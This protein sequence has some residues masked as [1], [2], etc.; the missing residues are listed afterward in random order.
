MF[1]T[2]PSPLQMGGGGGGGGKY[3]RFLAPLN[4]DMR[5]RPPRLSDSP[6]PWTPADQLTLHWELVSIL[7]ALS[8][9]RPCSIKSSQPVSFCLLCSRNIWPPPQS[10]LELQPETWAGSELGWSRAR[11]TTPFM[12]VSEDHQRDMSR[13][14]ARVRTTGTG[15][16]D[17]TAAAAPPAPQGTSHHRLAI[18]P[19]L[20]G[21]STPEPWQDSWGCTWIHLGIRPGQLLTKW[22]APTLG[23]QAQASLPQRA[24]CFRGKILRIWERVYFLYTRSHVGTSL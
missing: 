3:S 17:D 11:F 22:D 4:K 23:E 12:E 20:R 6:G 2:Q 16:V 8:S 5:G 10:L 13:C 24:G 9:P 19:T 18:T 21:R 14:P 15:S 1:T 7:A